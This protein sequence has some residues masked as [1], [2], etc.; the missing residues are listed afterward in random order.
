MYILLLETW[1]I[2]FW[3][4]FSLSSKFLSLELYHLFLCLEHYLFLS[5]HFIVTL[6]CKFTL[7]RKTLH[8]ISVST[9]WKSLKRNNTP[10][11]GH[12]QNLKA[13]LL[14][15]SP[16]FGVKVRMFGFKIN[17]ESFQNKGFSLSVE[18]STVEQE[19]LLTSTPFLEYNI[20]K[21][22]VKDT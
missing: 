22:M 8:F 19:S 11:G 5:L 21:W 10:S 4:L 1:Q 2:L 3:F 18:V 17:W 20:C 15:Y 14:K 7:L 12:L 16:K 13:A 6:I 9:H